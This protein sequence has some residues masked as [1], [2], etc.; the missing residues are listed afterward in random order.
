MVAARQLHVESAPQRVFICYRRDDSRDVAGRIRDHLAL[1]FGTAAVFEDVEAIPPG[2]DFREHI[3]EAISSC[4]VVL[5]LIGPGWLA[6]E[7]DG[8][9]PRVH[10]PADYV[11]LEVTGALAR[12]KLV[13]PVLVGGASMP[14]AE[15]LPEELRPLAFR[16]AA[17]VR[18]DP[19]FREDMRRLIAELR[20][21]L[22]A[23]ARGTR[24][25]RMWEVQPAAFSPAP[26]LVPGHGG[27]PAVPPSVAWTH[28]GAPAPGCHAATGSTGPRRSLAPRALSLALLLLAVVAMVAVAWIAAR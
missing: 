17:T 1:A 7:G 9:A 28:T 23:H 6:S 4:D 21:K 20:A 8:H 10:D 18:S 14:R 22:P 25:Q 13:V 27:V 16:H 11:R 5:V 2:A 24:E 19:D 12:E 3:A 15:A 26:P